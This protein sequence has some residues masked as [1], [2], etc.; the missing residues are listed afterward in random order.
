MSRC[1]PYFTDQEIEAQRDMS[2]VC[3]LS[4]TVEIGD[5]MSGASSSKAQ[6]LTPTPDLPST[7]YNL[8]TDHSQS[9]SSLWN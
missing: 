5:F 6:L 3:S 1:Y 2:Q 9:R 4:E 7:P 8:P